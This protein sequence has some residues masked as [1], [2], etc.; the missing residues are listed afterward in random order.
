MG[1]VYRDLK[2]D[3]TKK[4]ERVERRTQRAIVDLIRMCIYLVM[5]DHV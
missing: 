3:V 1:P 2:R 5:N 4:L